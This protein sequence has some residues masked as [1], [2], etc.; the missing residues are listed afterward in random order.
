MIAL[1]SSRSTNHWRPSCWHLKERAEMGRHR[2]PKKRLV[3]RS[4]V[5][6]FRTYL[7]C[8]IMPL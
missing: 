1:F 6:V 3:A 5:E 7:N 8:Y 2:G 4:T